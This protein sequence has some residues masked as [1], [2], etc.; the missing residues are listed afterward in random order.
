MRPLRVFFALTGL[1]VAWPV[2]ADMRP[3]DWLALRQ[4]QTV[5]LEPTDAS[6]SPEIEVLNRITSREVWAKD[7]A[8]LLRARKPLSR[9][10]PRTWLA[11]SPEL[12][13]AAGLD[14]Q[15]CVSLTCLVPE[16]NPDDAKHCPPSSAGVIPGAKPPPTSPAKLSDWLRDLGTATQTPL[17]AE[18]L[19]G[20]LP[21]DPEI[22]TAKGVLHAIWPDLLEAAQ[23]IGAVKPENIQSLVEE[24]LQNVQNRTAR[25]ARVA[26]AARLIGTLSL[27]GRKAA[28]PLFSQFLSRSERIDRTINEAASGTLPF[29]STLRGVEAD[30]SAADQLLTSIGVRLAGELK[31]KALE[32]DRRKTD[33]STSERDE[34]REL[35]ATTI[36]G[37]RIA[38]ALGKEKES[39]SGGRWELVAALSTKDKRT[40]KVTQN[41]LGP[42]GKN[43]SANI[44][45]QPECIV[46]TI[47]LGILI[48]NLEDRQGK[49]VYA[50]SPDTLTQSAVSGRF[51][52]GL[53]EVLRQLSAQ[54]KGI[55]S[56][57]LLD[58]PRLIFSRDLSEMVALRVRTT[59]PVLNIS[60]QTKFSLV[61]KGKFSLKLPDM[62]DYGSLLDEVKK[63]W[64]PRDVEIGPLTA[65]IASLELTNDALIKNG[66][67]LAVKGKLALGKAQLGEASA[68]IVDRAGIPQLELASDLTPL[69]RARIL[70]INSAGTML[71]R[72][73]QESFRGLEKDALR[74]VAGVLFVEQAR[75]SAD[76][77]DVA[78]RFSLD[79]PAITGSSQ[80]S[81]VTVE[82]TLRP[83]EADLGVS[84]LYK[85][86][87]SKAL[88]DV[89]NLQTMI[90]SR[91]KEKLGRSVQDATRAVIED[92][93][94]KAN[95]ALQPLKIGLSFRSSDK[96]AVGVLNVTWDRESV[97][98]GT[99]TII[100]NPPRIDFSGGQISEAD[101]QR[102]GQKLEAIAIDQL[103][104]FIGLAWTR[105]GVP[106]VTRASNGIALELSAEAPFLGCVPLPPIVFNGFQA[107]LD[108]AATAKTI[109]P[110]LV[111]KVKLLIPADLRE[112]IRDV[113]W[114]P[115]STS[116]ELEVKARAPGASFDLI[117][118]AR[119]D[120][121]NA[122]VDIEINT[123][124]IVFGEIFKNL[125]GLAGGDFK[126][127]PVAG[128]FALRA[129]GTINLGLVSVEVREMEVTPQRVYLP[130][131]G[132]KLPAAIAIGPFTVFPIGLQAKL[133][134][135]VRVAIIGDA[136]FAGLSH[137][138]RIRS[139][140]GVDNL[141]DPRIEMSGTMTVAEVLDL[142]EM[143]GKI[144]LAK[145]KLDADAKTIGVLG[146]IMPANQHLVVDPKHA[147][148][149]TSIKLLLLT[150]K[151]EGAIQFAEEPRISL[152]GKSSL[153]DLSNLKA[154]LASD[155]KLRQPKAS[156][157]GGIGMPPIGKIQFGAVASVQF[158]RL[159]ASII[160]IRLS[161]TLP[162]LKDLNGGLIKKL[163]EDLLEP[164][165]DLKNLQLK[166]INLTLA[167]RIGGDASGGG[168][169]KR[170]G[171]TDGKDGGGGPAIAP[172]PASQGGAVVQDPKDAVRTGSVPSEWQSGWLPAPSAPNML[173]AAR[174]KNRQQ[175]QWT[176]NIRAPRSVVQ[177]FR[178]KRPQIDLGKTATKVT[179]W[180]DCARQL[181]TIPETDAVVFFGGTDRPTIWHRGTEIIE[182]GAWIDGALKQV[183]LPGAAGVTP[184]AL[185]SAGTARLLEILYQSG[186]KGDAA[187]SVRVIR[188]AN[189]QQ[190]YQVS[191]QNSGVLH[192]IDATGGAGQIRSLRTSEPLGQLVLDTTAEP[193][194]LQAA[195]RETLLPLLFAGN[196]PR[197]LSDVAGRLLLTV[198]PFDGAPF[199]AAF[200]VSPPRCGTK[201]ELEG[202]GD[203]TSKPDFAD[204]IA[205][206]LL[207]EE[208]ACVKSARWMKLMTVVD[209]AGGLQRIVG[210]QDKGAGDWSL[211]FVD[212]R[213]FVERKGACLRSGLSGPKLR[214]LVEGWKRDGLPQAEKVEAL[215][216]ADY[217]LSAIL[218][219]IQTPNIDWQ[220]A[221]FPLN[222]VLMAECPA[223]K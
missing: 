141:P 10:E 68:Y 30:L 84:E 14:V 183:G 58:D 1:L 174:W 138:I 215:L 182:D 11:I 213:D 88:R 142:F 175:V 48:N 105:C 5:G 136:S 190:F 61:E 148:L 103:K 83:S 157:E 106:R 37:R 177:F 70:A 145:L 129:S 34:L 207:A 25:G 197:V 169:A 15:R 23:R 198:D 46:S 151:G 114:D 209:G 216:G 219:A 211:D 168:P 100:P 134:K 121:T 199:V 24:V 170:D 36:E 43:T 76:G 31:P 13:K 220:G 102:L 2:W 194:K 21:V 202:G 156:V 143:N 118:T 161:L 137:V 115:G 133:Q 35:S 166:N 111:E 55:P 95:M 120:L 92:V 98:L 6:G 4:L 108:V 205:A 189:N 167:P 119:V 72:V 192:L 146:A 39:E 173:C 193:A 80:V 78:V 110:L 117:G 206:A 109:R 125:T 149:D 163:F 124:D 188:L 7:L 126:V 93:I 152:E 187:S 85:Q 62:F 172:A 94:G 12:C 28:E 32:T 122:S 217:G 77:K 179:Y 165:I 51:V 47:G 140:I 66:T 196:V 147:K 33:C 130:E 38:L 135:P 49:L 54:H 159:H 144:D 176:G 204:P 128:R 91:L 218:K 112:H 200:S 116:V 212:Q 87:F 222:P 27:E 104:S 41:V 180:R 99:I 185:P 214:Q 63:A 22:I 221:G 107:Q 201:V 208:P 203:F 71:E 20:E 186:I 96:P 90:V 52:E 155:L 86:L 9:F 131:I 150:V 195:L 153:A 56:T 45:V 42:D 65:S 164:S 178:D 89:A 154:A 53:N 132:V 16:L 40:I 139:R 44:D 3:E 67:W 81:R 184:A 50:G 19:R 8:E 69:I 127:E 210:V 75:L 26:A 113:K 97:D 74:E 158:V 223:R 162:S 79:L 29:V 73:L 60:V 17:K 160:G 101:G 59:V 191:P 171:Q 18:L 57:L 181:E 82:G 64:T 123:K